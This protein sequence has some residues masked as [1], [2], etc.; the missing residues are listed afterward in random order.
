MSESY[1]D[2]PL[3]CRLEARLMLPE[4][5]EARGSLQHVFIGD[6]FCRAIFNFGEIALPEEL[7]SQLKR[8]EGKG[9]SCLRLDNKYYIREV[10]GL[11]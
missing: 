8:L 7:G 1:N 9:V 11:A 6:G 2:H 10:P 3:A 5:H 4:L